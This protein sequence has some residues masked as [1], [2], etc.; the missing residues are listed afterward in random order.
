M[1]NTKKQILGDTR[2]YRRNDAGRRN[3]AK[4]WMEHSFLF[5]VL[6]SLSLLCSCR[7]CTRVDVSYE[8]GNGKKEARQNTHSA[9]WHV[10]WPPP[11]CPRRASRTPDLP[12]P[13]FG[14][15]PGPMFETTRSENQG[16]KKPRR[17]HANIP[18]SAESSFRHICVVCVVLCWCVHV[19]V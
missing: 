13:A 6:A 3:D 18:S 19:S 17:A 7:L 16:R 5:L 10:S 12:R 1:Q 4:R 11:S 15:L 9:V 8:G 2:N 14:S